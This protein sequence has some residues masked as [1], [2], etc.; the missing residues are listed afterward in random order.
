MNL[1]SFKNL[2]TGRNYFRFR[3]K[4]NYL[5]VASS[6]VMKLALS[7]NKVNAE[8]LK[9][10]SYVKISFMEYISENNGYYTKTKS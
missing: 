9:E 7:K 1:Q 10:V 5:G 8:F 4:G 3:Y 6:V 2:S